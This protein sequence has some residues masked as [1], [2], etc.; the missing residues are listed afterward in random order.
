MKIRK[1]SKENVTSL[2][3]IDKDARLSKHR[4]GSSFG[5]QL[6]RVQGELVHKELENLYRDINQQGKLLIKTL[7]LKDL[8]KFRDMIQ[9]FLDYA[10]N[11]MYH[12]KEQ[13]GWDRRGRHKIYT[14]IE[15]VN[16]EL[17]DLTKMLLSEQKDQI[18]ILAK[19]DEIRGLLVDLYS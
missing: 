2:N 16:K 10:V 17:E 18:S 4:I 8:K 11:K 19:V 14:S 1:V 9:K 12:L 6:H 15:T 7:N 3:T 5:E 13:P